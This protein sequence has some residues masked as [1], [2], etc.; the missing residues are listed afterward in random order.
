VLRRSENVAR[1]AS[2]RGAS[3]HDVDQPM[4]PSQ[5]AVI[6]DEPNGSAV[7]LSIAVSELIWGP[8]RGNAVPATSR[9]QDHPLFG[10]GR[11]KRP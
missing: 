10:T 2:I 6:R 11:T 1:D 5:L 8:M 9:S 4:G 7:F 3:S